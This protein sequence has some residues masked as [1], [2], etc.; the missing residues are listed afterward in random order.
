MTKPILGIT[1]HGRA[2]AS[3]VAALLSRWGVPMEIR[4]PLVGE[5]LPEPL[6]CAGAVIFGGAM[7]TN[8]LHLDGIA[9]EVAWTERALACD[10]PLLGICLGG[11]MIA[12]AL[13]AEVAA[14]VDGHWEVGYRSVKPTL[15]G[16]DIFADHQTFFQWHGEGFSLPIGATRLA[17]TELYPQQAFKYGER[18]IGLQ[19][20]P[21]VS[22][23]LLR[24]WQAE[25]ADAMRYPGGDSIEQQL[26]DDT[27]FRAGAEA[28]LERL[29]R[30][31]LV[32]APPPKKTVEVQ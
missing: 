25:Y 8:D 6:Q 30:A 3:L 29:L 16:R 1:H 10:L 22:H 27:V 28:W 17:G 7:S 21:E 32:T 4:Q 20:H 2:E 5:T 14:R 31:W 11:Q 18:V 24:E 9:T 23:Q 12:R 26:A 13:G 15:E 19:F